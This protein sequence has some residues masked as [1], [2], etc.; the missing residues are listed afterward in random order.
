MRG[1]P[2][3]EPTPNSRAVVQSLAVFGHQQD[4]IA[5]H[6]GIDAKT[7]RKHYRAELDEGIMKV[8]SAV[9]NFIVRAAT[10]AALKEGVGATYSDCLRAAFFYGKTKMGLSERHEI[11]GPDGGPIRVASELTDEEL[12]KIAAGKP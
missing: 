10:G 7:L 12:A 3:H 8:H 5:K 6:I 4:E 1:R 2:K 9:G 11:S